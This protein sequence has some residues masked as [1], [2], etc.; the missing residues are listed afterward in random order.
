MENKKPNTIYLEHL[1]VLR[2]CK[3]L[4]NILHN[5][6][7]IKYIIIDLTDCN[8]VN[9]YYVKN[10]NSLLVNLPMYIK[11]ID[12]VISKT[13][14]YNLNRMRIK[15]RLDF[16]NLP[17]TIEK[18]FTNNSDFLNLKTPFGCRV[19]NTDVDYIVQEY[20]E[21]RAETIPIN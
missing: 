6:E 20:E 18:I 17:I 10:I 16:S 19:I 14:S 15:S 3:K 8:L 2:N 5:N 9:T 12:L 13:T 21:F 1:T 11:V 4:N 7:N